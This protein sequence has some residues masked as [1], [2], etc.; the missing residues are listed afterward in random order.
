MI[1]PNP[2]TGTSANFAAAM[3]NHIWQST[4]CAALIALVILAFRNIQARIRFAL[5]LAASVKFLI[6]FSLL[7][8]LGSHLAA[9][10]PATAT[11]AGLSA[12]MTAIT[13]PFAP[14]ATAVPTHPD[15]VAGIAPLLP[16]TLALLWLSGCI[17][18][19]ASWSLR[20]LRVAA[21]IHRAT[22]LVEGREVAA[23]R[24]IE[25]EHAVRRQAHFLLSPDP[26][27]PGVFGVLRPALLWPQ[28]ISAHL[29][30][31]Q[32]D[33][34]LT[35]EVTHIRRRDNLTAALHMLVEA[36]FWFHPLVW[37][38][39]ARLMD[40]RERACDEA[41]LTLGNQPGIYAE[42]ILKAC[43]FCVESPLACVAGVSGSNLK[44]R[45]TRIMNQQLGN[46]LTAAGKLA[47][48]S[49]A[50]AALAAP[51]AVGIL[52]PAQ[53]AAQQPLATITSDAPAFEQ[54]SVKPSDP[55]ETESRIELRPGYL[56]QTGATLKT[57]ISMAY[58][59]QEYQI[60]GEPA[61]V[62]T[63]R[64]DIEARW[65][66]AP[67]AAT[68]MLGVPPS[69]PLPPSAPGRTSFAITTDR[70]PTADGGMA[71]SKAP[72][73]VTPAMRALL[74]QKFNL[75][76]IDASQSLPVYDLVVSQNGLEL[77]PNP[78]NPAPLEKQMVT[79]RIGNSTS[80]TDFV[81]TNVTP[82]ILAGMLSQQL[83][84][85]V[86]D[87]TGLTSRYDME[88]RW[89]K[90]QEGFDPISAAVEDQLGLSLR[91][92]QAPVPV[93]QITSV[94]KPTGN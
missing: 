45:I 1:M 22:P 13:Q 77:T 57:L 75:K 88:I 94:E 20:W 89:P 15:G 65:K 41:V 71:P 3:V 79:V 23:L 43:R 78:A 60:T 56:S 44:R 74:A 86:I 58:G 21:G 8:A 34:I 28:G 18:V 76:L 92:S 47:L 5:W 70:P 10:R 67:G 64:F 27:E 4:L 66:L 25:R 59:V 2:F 39:G 53:V 24:R 91:P 36:I 35:H 46:P 82:D 61:W 85:K 30:D 40:E 33:A 49:L 32:L 31:Q 72:G 73:M 84:R 62:N 14:Q 11:T 7:I 26:M 51:L 12:T 90:D 38:L 81:L 9:P 55:S 68:A 6:P 63:D 80:Q 17:S 50:V 37:W 69:G 19:F 42:S 29:D 48:A 16:L 83:H 52:H 93:L 87:K 54:L